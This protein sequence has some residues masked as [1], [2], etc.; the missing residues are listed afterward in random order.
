MINGIIVKG[1]GGFYY[2]K[3]PDGRT[4]ECRARG[5]LRKMGI[6]PT[7]GDCAEI[8]VV[9][10]NP[11]EGAIEGIGQRKNILVRPP[12][13][14]I[15]CIAVVAA[16]ASPAPDTFLID[17]L[18]V[19]AEKNK[20]Q[21]VIV[22]NKTDIS[23]GNELAK[24]YERAGYRVFKVCAENG[25]GIDELKSFT[26]GKITAFA[27]NSGVGKSSILRRFG[28]DVETGEIS[29]IERGKH[30]TRHV[31]LFPAENGGYVMDTPGFSLLDI[32]KTPAD[33]LCGYFPEFEK[34]SG[35]CKF[36]GCV[37]YGAKPRDCGVCAAAESGE[38]AKSRYESY[39]ALYS[40]LKEIKSYD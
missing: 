4:A 3:T 23:D 17:K 13:A 2:V 21:A 5:R 12:V 16:A 19:C 35:G 28:L 38:I 26:A 31:E 27:G 34:F 37:H 15:D 33:E 11:Y 8:T 39:T 40:A 10:E 30:T 1:I 20:I 9:N 32:G 29:K 14:N 25:S 24:T 6:T 36:A 7:V 22:I 18:L